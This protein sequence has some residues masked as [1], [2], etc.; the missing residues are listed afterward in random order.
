MAV[1]KFGIGK[2]K[3]LE[4]SNCLPGKQTMQCYLMLQRLL[5]Q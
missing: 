5:G 1:T 2:W 3:E 4:A